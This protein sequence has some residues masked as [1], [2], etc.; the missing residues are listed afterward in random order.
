VRLQISLSRRS[1]AA[2]LPLPAVIIGYDADVRPCS[3]VCGIC[4]EQMLKRQPVSM[5]ASQAFRW[6]EG[7]NEEHARIKGGHLPPATK[8]ECTP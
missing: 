6:I 4:G 1:M 5:S 2:M 7:L 3:V 8:S